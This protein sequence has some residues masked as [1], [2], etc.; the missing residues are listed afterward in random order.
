MKKA[1]IMAL[2]LCLGLIGIPMLLDLVGYCP[3]EDGL[4]SV[5]SVASA[6]VNKAGVEAS[7]NP[8]DAILERIGV[9]RG[10]CVVLGDPKCELALQLARESELLIYAQFPR[11][12]DMETACRVTD[13]AGLYGTRIFIE[14]GP[15]TRL[16]L[17]DNLADALIAVGEATGISESEAIRV[18]H[19][20]GK[21]ILGR[22]E[23][24]KPF[25]EGVDD[26]SHPYHG[27]DNNPQSKDRIA[28]AP[29]LTHF[30]SDPR[31]APVP[32]VAV[33]S[34][35]RVFKAF[36]HLAFKVR[37]EALL[38]TLVAFNGYNGTMLWKRP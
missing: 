18:L 12:E 15:L 5:A 19:P 3:F 11:A 10:I 6:A 38:N 27:P 29:Y 9:S 35:G 20:Q 23:L 30:L 13:A 24:I 2:V 16:H 1:S 21:A 17:A 31:Y 36:G 34:A 33:A 8:K 22:K 28:R 26:W 7:A 14:K 25:P 4:S 32:Q 37:E